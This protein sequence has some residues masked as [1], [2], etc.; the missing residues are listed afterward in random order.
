MPE[1][2][3]REVDLLITGAA[4]VLTCAADA[5]DLIGVTSGGVA[6]DAGAIAAVG[7]VSAWTGRQVVDAQGGVVLP[8]FVDAHTHVVFGGSR[9]EEYAARVAGV[10]P[11]AGA[12][13]GIVGTTTATR[14]CGVAELVAQAAPRIAEMVAAGTTT[15]ESK[16]GY[17]LQPEAELRL[18]E[19]NRLL[20]AGTDAELVSTYLGAHAFPTDVAPGD[21]VDQILDQIPDVA[22]AGLAEFCDAYCDQGYFDLDQTR[23]I[24]VRGVEHGLAPKLHLDAYSHTGA[25]DLAIEVDAVSVDHLNFTTEPELRR[26][27]EAGIVGVYMPCLD[28]AVAHPHPVQGRLLAESGMEIALAT[29]VCPGCMVTNMQLAIAMACRSGGLSV[30]QAVRAATFGAARSLNRS[31]RIGSLEPGKQ[32]DL[33]VL[34]LPRHEDIAYRIGRNS[35]TT[36]VKSGTVLEE[37]SW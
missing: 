35:V 19:A 12:S 7:D 1:P 6:I 8:G 33:I 36:V 4:E 37:T 32:A 24:L 20:D 18:L 28:Y 9:V 17:G 29:D 3:P 5:P 21:Y 15:L 2:S 34:D 31:D 16:T 23:R 30:A 25:A 11:P 10:E 13:V 27:A 26:L 14:A 22:A